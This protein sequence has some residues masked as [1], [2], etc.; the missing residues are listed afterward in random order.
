VE[1]LNLTGIL[2]GFLGVLVFGVVS[3]AALVLLLTGRTA[4]ARLTFASGWL[5]ASLIE[6]LAT[7]SFL[8]KEVNNDLGAPLTLLAALI[9]LLGGVGQFLAA[10][11]NGLTYAAGLACA[12]GS[13]VFLL[14]ISGPDIVGGGHLAVLLGLGIS[15]LQA[16]GSLCIGAFADVVP[17]PSALERPE[18]DRPA[19]PGSAF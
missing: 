6:V 19:G 8:S 15:V 7:L 1:G 5:G 14:S 3:L 2:V 12:F 4:T 13:I 18:G 11:R 10:R 16:A 9:L 17:R